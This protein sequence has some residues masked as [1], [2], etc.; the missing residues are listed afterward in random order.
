MFLSKFRPWYPG[1]DTDQ[2]SESQPIPEPP[3]PPSTEARNSDLKPFITP[4]CDSPLTPPALPIPDKNKE[5]DEGIDNDSKKKDTPSDLKMEHGDTPHPKKQKIIRKSYSLND[6]D[7]LHSCVG[8]GTYRITAKNNRFGFY[9]A[10]EA[11]NKNMDLLI[12]HICRKGRYLDTFIN[13]PN[14]KQEENMIVDAGMLIYQHGD[15][16]KINII[17]V[18]HALIFFYYSLNLQETSISILDF[19]HLKWII[20]PKT[21]YGMVFNLILN[22]SYKDFIWKDSNIF[23]IIRRNFFG[24]NNSSFIE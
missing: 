22:L 21:Q 23:S 24:L 9:K 4:K 2:K 17:N 7:S 14:S 20:I 12:K 5:T 1:F 6:L 11:A 15:C 3:P 16:I 10:Y 19:E 13:K 18:Y 8:W